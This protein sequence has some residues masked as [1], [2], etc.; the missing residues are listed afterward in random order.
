MHVADMTTLDSVATG[1]L[2]AATAI[3]E[4][5]TNVST[6]RNAK[7]VTGKP[8]KP[9]RC[10]VPKRSILKSPLHEIARFYTFSFGTSH[11]QHLEMFLDI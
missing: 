11:L 9:E 10:Q 1:G 8:R 2:A 5:W 4:Q 3:Q 7:G 6:G